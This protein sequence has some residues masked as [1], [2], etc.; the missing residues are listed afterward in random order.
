VEEILAQE[1][2]IGANWAMAETYGSVNPGVETPRQNFLFQPVSQFLATALRAGR[3]MG[4]R[5]E[6]DT[7]DN[8]LHSAPGLM[9]FNRLPLSLLMM[10][11]F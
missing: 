1:S 11:P 9:M 5:A 4:E 7:N 6:I 8:G 10:R 3:L 2:H